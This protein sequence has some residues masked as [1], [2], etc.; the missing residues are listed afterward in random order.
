VRPSSPPRGAVARHDLQHAQHIRTVNALNLAPRGSEARASSQTSEVTAPASAES[1]SGKLDRLAR[2]S[3]GKSN[4]AGIR[5]QAAKQPHPPL[6]SHRQCN[7]PDRQRA[8]RIVA[9]TEV[10]V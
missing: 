2:R 10:A 4:H 1:R 5:T 3:H 6:R 7:R 9:T 8:L